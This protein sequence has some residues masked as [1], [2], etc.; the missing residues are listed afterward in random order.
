MVM[1]SGLYYAAY[2][3][4]G[5]MFACSAANLVRSVAPLAH[6]GLA[7]PKLIA[8]P[9]LSGNYKLLD[10]LWWTQTWN[11][12]GFWRC[13]NKSDTK[14]H[15]SRAL[16]S[17]IPA[18]LKSNF[19]LSAEYISEEI[20]GYHTSWG[21]VLV[22]FVLAEWAMQPQ[23][24]SACPGVPT[25][26]A[27]LP[28]NSVRQPDGREVGGRRNTSCVWR[29]L[30]QSSISS[31]Q[32][33]EAQPSMLGCCCSRSVVRQQQWRGSTPGAGCQPSKPLTSTDKAR[34]VTRR[35]A[36]RQ[37]HDCGGGWSNGW[38]A[39]RGSQEERALFQLYRGSLRNLWQ[40]ISPPRFP[41]HSSYA[42][43]R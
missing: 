13:P 17:L 6:L 5:L 25:M 23:D 33:W 8:N 29:G 42:F 36:P 10:C 7:S 24:R 41:S 43:S 21:Q 26:L 40:G 35:G 2:T 19:S 20:G 37:Q 22:K 38:N 31:S 9:F 4:Q 28:Q 32:Q 11:Q 30:F 39:G 12:K 15:C 3:S 14:S 27:H 1:P 18:A 16:H 34:G